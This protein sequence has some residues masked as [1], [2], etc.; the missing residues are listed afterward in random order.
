[1]TGLISHL[2]SLESLGILDPLL[3]LGALLSPLLVLHH[4]GTSLIRNSNP[5]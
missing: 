5:P 4:R 3:D 2:R 1:V